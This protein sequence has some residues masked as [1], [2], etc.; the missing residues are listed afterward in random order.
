MPNGRDSPVLLT[1]RDLTRMLRDKQI[2]AL[3]LLELQLDRVH[4]VNPKINAI[5]AFD[6]ERAGSSGPPGAVPTIC[7]S[8]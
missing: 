4:E 7:A 5:V 1:V 3:E 8:L 2:S 6:E